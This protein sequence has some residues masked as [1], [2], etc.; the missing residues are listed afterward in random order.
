[1]AQ[2]NIF[3]LDLLAIVGARTHATIAAASFWVLLIALIIMSVNSPATTSPIE[4][5]LNFLLLGVMIW[6][7]VAV[8]L[9]QVAMGIG[10][11]TI[12]LAAIVNLML[13]MLVPLAVIS[14][15]TTILKLAGA[16]TGFAGMSQ[17]ERD[18]ITPGHCRGCGY[19]RA[20]IGLLDPCPE[21][22][23]VPQVI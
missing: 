21:C 7:V 23:R 2:K 19:S 5:V 4:L 18:K 16:K 17:S 20:G 22:T 1:M 10:I 9:L 6:Q 11:V 13:P 3:Q 15:S 8:I 12:V 14:Q